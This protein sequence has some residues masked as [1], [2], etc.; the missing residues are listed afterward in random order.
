MWGREERTES[1]GPVI[2]GHCPKHVAR[3]S[4]AEEMAALVA[5]EATIQDQAYSFSNI[6]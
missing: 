5:L 4:T 2:L 6:L 3:V 1:R